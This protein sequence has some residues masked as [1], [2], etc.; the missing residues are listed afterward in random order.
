MTSFVRQALLLLYFVQ[1]KKRKLHNGTN[2]VCVGKRQK[3]NQAPSFTSSK[4]EIST[5]SSSPN[6]KEGWCY[7]RI[8]SYLFSCHVPIFRHVSLN[9]IGLA[10][11]KRNLTQHSQEKVNTLRRPK[12]E[13]TVLFLIYHIL[14]LSIIYY[15]VFYNFNII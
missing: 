14:F 3:E 10:F 15:H 8:I 2:S 9:N 1:P 13:V 7:L 4:G 5:Q 12:R 11:G 6:W